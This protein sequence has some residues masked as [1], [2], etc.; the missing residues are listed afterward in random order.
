DQANPSRLEQMHDI[1]LLGAL[2][3][4]WEPVAGRVQHD[5]YHVYTV[6][7][8]SL[9][10]VAMMK[11]LARGEHAK[12]HPRPSEEIARIERPAVLYLATLIHDIGK[13]LGR[14]HPVRGAALAVTVAQ[15]L[16]MDEDE[17]RQVEVL[18]RDHL[19]MALTSQRRD[20]E[21]PGLIAGLARLCRDPEG[22]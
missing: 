22:L 7:Q 3:P 5:V 17:V 6:D 10:A 18:V 15:S 14:N 4:E 19:V 1:G 11:A 13:P 9:Y 12:D 8:H 2:I 21:D 16:G 20:L